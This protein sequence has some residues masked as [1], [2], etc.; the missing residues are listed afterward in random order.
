MITTEPVARKACCKQYIVTSVWTAWVR[1]T[2]QSIVF[3]TRKWLAA[4]SLRVRLGIVSYSHSAGYYGAI[5]YKLRGLRIA[6]LPSSWL[7]KHPLRRYEQTWLACHFTNKAAILSLSYLHGRKSMWQ[8]SAANEML[9]FESCESSVLVF[10]VDSTVSSWKKRILKC[11]P[12]FEDNVEMERLK[13]HWEQ[14]GR[15]DFISH[16]H[17]RFL[18]CA[19]SFIV[20]PTLPSPSSAVLLKVSINTPG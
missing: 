9:V 14:D 3:F 17:V 11:R 4:L 7:Q 20:L 10:S 12:C 13:S 15:N 2:E 18:S 5:K 16:I 19:I 6:P 1:N 8:L